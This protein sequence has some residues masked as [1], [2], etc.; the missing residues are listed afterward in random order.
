MKPRIILIDDDHG[1]MDYFVEALRIR[2]FE[3]RQIDST[4]DA[5]CWLED[6]GAQPPDLVVLDLMLPPGTRLTL[7]ETDGGLRSGVVIAHAVRKRFPD[8]PIV[9]FTN[10]NDDDVTK[11]LPERTTTR[12]KFE[13][14]PFAFADFVA[15]KSF[16][17][18]DDPS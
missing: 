14:S 11:A 9:A 8:V 1:P 18:T 2:G 10:H 17:A 7:E 16:E 12:A 6:P 4:D 3:V 13:T 15:S 5:F